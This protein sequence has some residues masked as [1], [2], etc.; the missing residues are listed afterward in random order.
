MRIQELKVGDRVFDRTYGDTG[1]VT[2]VERYPMVFGE[3]YWI[4]VRWDGHSKPES[5][6]ESHVGLVRR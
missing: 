1:V 3:S 5:C 6:L 2:E 4:K